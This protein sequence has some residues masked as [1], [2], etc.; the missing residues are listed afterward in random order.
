MGSGGN[1]EDGWGTQTNS[2][3]SL[4]ALSWSESEAVPG[5]SLPPLPS[6][7]RSSGSEATTRSD[8]TNVVRVPFGVRQPRRLRPTRPD[9]WATLVLPF[10]VGGS[11]P[12]PPQAA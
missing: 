7:N 6:I 3:R 11:T 4:R 12:P 9:H 1:S 2:G 8:G 10:Q 5:P